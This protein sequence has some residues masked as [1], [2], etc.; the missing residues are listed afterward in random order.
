MGHL[1]KYLQQDASAWRIVS[2]LWIPGR[3]ASSKRT[4]KKLNPILQLR[5]LFSTSNSTQKPGCIKCFLLVRTISGERLSERAETTN[6]C[7][8]WYLWVKSGRVTIFPA[9]PPVTMQSAHQS[10]SD[11]PMY[12]IPSQKKREIAFFYRV[13]AKILYLKSTVCMAS[14]N[15]VDF[16]SLFRKLLMKK[17]DIFCYL[18]YFEITKISGS[19]G[20]AQKN[21]QS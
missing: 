10:D 14:E 19:G 20:W 7:P 3:N 11:T 8:N 16:P 6:S 12:S 1:N 13:S 21:H 15:L 5:E 4:E 17:T 2:E 9:E 18:L